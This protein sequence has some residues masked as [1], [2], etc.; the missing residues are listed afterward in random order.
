V[1]GDRSQGRH[2]GGKLEVAVAA[3][4]RRHRVALHRVHVHVDREQVVA[5]LGAVLG[6]LV[7]E[8]ARGQSLALEAALHVRQGEQDGV[9]P[10]RV[11]LAA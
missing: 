11:E 2:V 4:P 3:G 9:D 7:E 1:P 10:A 5:A 6:H 8:V